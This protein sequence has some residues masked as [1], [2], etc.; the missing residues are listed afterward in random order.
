[1][2]CI[3]NTSFFSKKQ[4]YIWVG[5][6]QSVDYIQAGAYESVGAGQEE[7]HRV[8]RHPWQDGRIERVP[9]DVEH[10]VAEPQRIQRRRVLVLLG[11]YFVDISIKSVACYHKFREFRGTFSGGGRTRAVVVA[12]PRQSR[13]STELGAGVR[14]RA[15]RGMCT[16]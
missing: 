16:S 4:I 6:N 12:T 10:R 3:I 9:E 11:R 2:N 15:Q 8:G 1:M 13:M 14:T 5:T 7:D